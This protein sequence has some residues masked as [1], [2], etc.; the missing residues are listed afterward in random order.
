MTTVSRIRGGG[1]DCGVI[2]T[3]GEKLGN[4]KVS[5]GRRSQKVVLRIEVCV[6]I[7]VKDVRGLTMR[8]DDE[9]GEVVGYW[10]MCWGCVDRV[11]GRHNSREN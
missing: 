5:L 10:G 1:L 2:S 4:T 7:G 6:Q 8:G 9:S 3:R 11:D